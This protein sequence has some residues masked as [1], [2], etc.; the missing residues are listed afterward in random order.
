MGVTVFFYELFQLKDDLAAIL[1]CYC[2]HG[3]VTNLCHLTQYNWKATFGG[4]F[5]A[6]RTIDIGDIDC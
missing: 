4:K 1:K 3:N 2:C 6:I 5:E